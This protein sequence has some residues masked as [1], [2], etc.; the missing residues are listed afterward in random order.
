MIP[1]SAS[2]ADVS[3]NPIIVTIKKCLDDLNEIS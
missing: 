1:A 3:S 2:G